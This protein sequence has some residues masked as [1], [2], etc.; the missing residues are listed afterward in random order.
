M[1]PSGITG[2]EIYKSIRRDNT[3]VGKPV[4]AV[5]ASD[6]TIE[7]PKAQG[8]GF[9]GFISKPIDVRSFP[10]LIASIMHG[11]AVWD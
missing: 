7:I 11:E 10:H 6:S 8:L 9:A 4:V 5:S 1:F 2:Y 3:L